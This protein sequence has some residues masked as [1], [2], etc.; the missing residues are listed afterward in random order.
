M[1]V[2]HE[3]FTD[4]ASAGR[5]GRSNAKR[6]TSS[7]AICCASA[8]LPPLP[9]R[10]ALF[11]CLSA[12]TKISQTFATVNKTSEL[13]SMPCFVAIDASI[14]SRTRCSNSLVC[15]IQLSVFKRQL[16]VQGV[17]SGQTA[18]CESPGAGRPSAGCSA[19]ENPPV[20]TATFPKFGTFAP[21]QLLLQ[22]GSS[23]R[24]E[25]LAEKYLALNHPG[26]PSLSCYTVGSADLFSV[27]P[28]EAE[29]SSRFLNR[30][31]RTSTRSSVGNLRGEVESPLQATNLPGKLRVPR[32]ACGFRSRLRTGSEL[33][34]AKARS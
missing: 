6:P 23:R 9:N 20:P 31:G 25:R 15:F 8:A 4:R 30:L 17:A 12:L 16:R 18:A 1:D 19:Q 28:Q 3:V 26:L 11:P 34:P 32:C 22:S 14:N 13:R 24:Q 21:Q 33:F 29:S 7:A 10:S 5:A 2:T 27:F